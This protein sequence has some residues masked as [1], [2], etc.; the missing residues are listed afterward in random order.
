MLLLHHCCQC[1][2]SELPA[3]AGNSSVWC[4]QDV[5]LW[6]FLLF[7]VDVCFVSQLQ[8]ADSV[9]LGSVNKVSGGWF[10]VF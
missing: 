7:G 10:R 3:I 4:W 6:V 9:G 5:W 1:P 8:S 2:V